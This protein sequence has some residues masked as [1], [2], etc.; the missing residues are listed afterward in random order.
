MYTNWKNVNDLNYINANKISITLTND[1]QEINHT[2]KITTT[3]NIL[4]PVARCVHDVS[5]ETH[6]A[7]SEVHQPACFVLRSL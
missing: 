7:H 1:I 6:G 4:T 5:K 2:N 3:Y